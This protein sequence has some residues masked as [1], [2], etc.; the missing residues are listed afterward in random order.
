[1][2]ARKHV[3]EMRPRD[4]TERKRTEEERTRLLG[5]L[6][7]GRERTRRLAQQVVSAREEE[8]RRLSRELHDQASQ[9]LTVLTIKL[10][11]LRQELPSENSTAR[12]HVEELIGLTEKLGNQIAHV[13]RSLRPP[14]LDS[15]GLSAALEELCR[16]FSQHSGLAV[17][18]RG[19][20]IPGLANITCT[21]LYRG[22]QE[23]LT[24]VVRHAQAQHADVRLTADGRVLQLSV[25]HDG[26]AFDTATSPSGPGVT[27]MRERVDQMGGQLRVERQPGRETRLVMQIPYEEFQ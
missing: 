3:I 21:C 23:A 10:D 18:Y 17:D 24:N 15:L 26:R 16:E 5:Q 6:R 27:R 1:M 20:K 8:R 4:I 11:L 19:S 12:E 13:V 14:A 7:I 22:L 9:I 25:A 2:A